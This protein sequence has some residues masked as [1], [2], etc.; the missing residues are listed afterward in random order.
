VNIFFAEYAANTNMLYCRDGQAGQPAQ[1][2]AC[3]SDPI[4]TGSVGSGHGRGMSQWGSQYWARGLSYQGLPTAPR[5]W[6]CILD[7]YYNDNSNSTDVATG[8]RTAYTQGAAT[9]GQIAYRS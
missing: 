3:M 6:R 7:H 4:A 1:N 2:W 9:Y 8:N 5:D